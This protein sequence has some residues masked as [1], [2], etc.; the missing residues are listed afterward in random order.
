LVTVLTSKI[1]YFNLAA[2]EPVIVHAWQALAQG[3]ANRP[4]PQ[5]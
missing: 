5:A 1:F 2:D 3:T 4:A